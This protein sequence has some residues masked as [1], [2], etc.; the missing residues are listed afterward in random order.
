MVL[1]TDA[2]DISKVDFADKTWWVT[3][4]NNESEGTSWAVSSYK[5]YDN[6][7]SLKTTKT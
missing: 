1:K 2:N 4:E 5:E 3:F 7:Y 6:I